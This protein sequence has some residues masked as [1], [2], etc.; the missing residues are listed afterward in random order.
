MPSIAWFPFAILLFGLNEQAI[1]FVVVLGA[2]PEHRQRRHLR[3]RPR[4]AVVRP[5]RARARRR[6]RQPLP[7][8]RAARRR[9]PAY[10]AGLTQGW[11]FAW[12]SLMAGELLVII[13]EK[14]SLGASLEFARQ[15]SKAPAAA[16]DHARHPHPRHARRRPVLV[17]RPPH[18][19]PPRARGRPDASDPADDGNPG[20]SAS[21]SSRGTRRQWR[22]ARL[23]QDRLR[24]ARAARAGRRA[25]GRTQSGWSR[26]SDIATAQGIPVKFLE[27]ILRQLRQAGHRDEPARCGGRLPPRPRPQHGSPSPTSTRALDGPLVG[28]ARSAARGRRVHR[29]LGAP[30]RGLDRRARRR[31]A[32]CSSRSRSPTSRPARLPPEL[33]R[34]LAAPGAWERR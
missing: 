30:A 10:V 25:R 22:H 32:R 9:C 20:G 13:A 23:R 26:A 24:H 18:A 21:A 16:G 12:R 11:A 31:C 27:G 1:L 3:H 2:A 19:A 29:G 14:P 4:A 28:R 8:H 33:S 6:H 15:F 7:R 5:A 34:L 17:V